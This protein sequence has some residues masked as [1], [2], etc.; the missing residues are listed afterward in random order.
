[1]GLARLNDMKAQSCGL[2]PITFPRRCYSI[3]LLHESTDNNMASASIPLFLSFQLGVVAKAS[4]K[5]PD[6]KAAS[7]LP[8]SLDTVP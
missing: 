5:V 7:A 6:A 3:H 2:S 1:M 8:F 4:A